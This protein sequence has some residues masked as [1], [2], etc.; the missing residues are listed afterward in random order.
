MSAA[1][2]HRPLLDL[3]GA[4]RKAHATRVASK[5][6]N[7]DSWC[8]RRDSI[9]RLP[10]STQRGATREEFLGDKPPN[11][12]VITLS[13]S[14]SPEKCVWYW[15]KEPE[16]WA[17]KRNVFAPLNASTN[18][19]TRK[20]YDYNIAFIIIIWNECLRQT[21]F[22]RF[23]VAELF[24]CSLSFASPPPPPPPPP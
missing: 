14:E 4:H 1:A 16:E 9:V 5:C 21:D 10:A 22:S 12:C 13:L 19:C 17:A 7:R 18:E 2:P 20:R 3:L 15:W 24:F 8:F 11:G 23:A 6:F